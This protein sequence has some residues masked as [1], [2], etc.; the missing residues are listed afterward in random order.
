MIEKRFSYGVL[1]PNVLYIQK[2]KLL[3]GNSGDQQ[4]KAVDISSKKISTLTYFPKGFIDGIRPDGNG[5]LLV[6]L[7]R[8]K[9]SRIN[10]YCNIYD[11]GAYNYYRRKK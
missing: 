11:T 4:L 7:W 10:F 1:D 9:I 2:N 8:G 5:N 6:S 3:I